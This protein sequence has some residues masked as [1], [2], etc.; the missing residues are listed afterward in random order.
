M[1]CLPCIL[2][3]VV[4]C[5]LKIEYAASQ[6]CEASSVGTNFIFDLISF[7]DRVTA[8]NIRLHITPVLQVPAHVRVTAPFINMDS[9]Y[10]VS[11]YTVIPLNGTLIQ[12]EYGKQFKGIEVSSDVNIS[13]AVFTADND[14]LTEGFLALP[15]SALGTRYT[16]AS[17][18]PLSTFSSEIL[19]VGVENDTDVTLSTVNGWKEEH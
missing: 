16:A 15:I 14:D 8:N 2:L 18:I 12:F 4:A 9:T 7:A 10:T 19:V 13:L 5:H 17:Y 6:N 11:N 3:L 1:K